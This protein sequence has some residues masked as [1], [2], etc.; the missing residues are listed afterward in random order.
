MATG[1]VSFS[2]AIVPTI[3]HNALSWVELSRMVV[4][5]DNECCA[6]HLI[7]ANFIE[8]VRAYVEE[9]EKNKVSCSFAIELCEACL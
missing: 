5:I 1:F 6:Y 9:L 8:S 4:Q 2:V 7:S 3:D